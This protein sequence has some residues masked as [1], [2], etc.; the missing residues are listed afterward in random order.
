MNE[1]SF[2]DAHCH[3]ES[4]SGGLLPHILHIT[5]GYSHD[6]NQKNLR[7]A[8]EYSNAYLCAGIAPQEAM[9]HKDIKILL[10][11]WE[12]AIAGPIAD[13]GKLV[14]IGEIGLDYKW[15]A[16]EEERFLQHE[17]FISQLGLAERLSLPVV[18]H[19]R[20]AEEKCL[21]ILKNFNLD[22]MMHCFSGKSETAL[23]AV[24]H[25]GVVSIP[26]LRSK[27]RKAFIRDLPIEKLL[28]ESDAPYI[29]KT[30]QDSMESIKM[31]AE[32][33]ELPQESVSRQTLL[34]TIEF[35]RLK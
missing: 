30:P 26:P 12:D 14:A 27:E 19:S 35:F 18:I 1:Y 28:A 9:K 3:L 29:G 23:A 4:I 32:I 22:Y 10:V 11:E 25:K 15:A 6:S 16:T 21:E 7:I 24:A 2:A 34:N 13:S 8:K 17:C 20:D 33:K 31:I 5:S